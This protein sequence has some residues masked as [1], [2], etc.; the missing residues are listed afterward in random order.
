MQFKPR[1]HLVP[2]SRGPGQQ[3]LLPQLGDCRFR[4]KNLC[5]H[6]KPGCPC[7]GREGEGEAL[8]RWEDPKWWKP[9]LQDEG[10]QVACWN[11]LICLL[12]S[13]CKLWL[14]C[15][16]HKCLC[17]MSALGRGEIP[18]FS[19]IFSIMMRVPESKWKPDDLCDWKGLWGETLGQT[20]LTVHLRGHAASFTFL[21][22]HRLPSRKLCGCEV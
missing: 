9:W 7:Q 6:P 4:R 11:F 8:P 3:C 18:W 5:N 10:L 2:L 1:N 17:W 21:H 20:H 14:P 12:I 19:C 15:P 16:L 13:K 22:T